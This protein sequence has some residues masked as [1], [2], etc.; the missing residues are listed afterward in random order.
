MKLNHLLAVAFLAVLT[1]TA[2]ALPSLDD[3]Q[4]EIAKG[5]YALAQEMMH[6]VVAAKPD[7]ARAHYVYAEL[8]AHDKRFALASEEAAQAR[9]IDPGLSFTEPKAACF[10]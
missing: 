6:A 3:V 8:L 2:F 4:A 1:S 7:S 9:R 10:R 5:N